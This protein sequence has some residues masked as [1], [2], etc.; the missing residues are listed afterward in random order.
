VKGKRKNLSYRKTSDRC[1]E[2]T[3]VA[4]VL[5]KLQDPKKPKKNRKK[6]RGGKNSED[7]LYRLLSDSHSLIYS[8]RDAKGT[9]QE[10][11]RRVI[12]TKPTSGSRGKKR[13][14]SFEAPPSTTPRNRP[15]GCQAPGLVER[16]ERGGQFEYGSRPASAHKPPRKPPPMFL[17]YY[18]EEKNRETQQKPCYPNWTLT[19]I[20]GTR[21]PRNRP[22][23]GPSREPNG[24]GKHNI[25]GKKGSQKKTR[26]GRGREI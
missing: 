11:K 9:S 25:W 23:E 4:V 5:S 26:A 10:E 1:K 18:R 15:P 21:P 16:I 6:R 19:T 20:N 17:P 2:S 24:R 7:R 14:V 13:E 3:N 12:M 8:G 22:C